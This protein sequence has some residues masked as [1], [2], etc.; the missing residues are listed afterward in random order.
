[1]EEAPLL[2]GRRRRKLK[3]VKKDGS[4]GCNAQKKRWRRKSGEPNEEVERRTRQL[5]LA[6]GKLDEKNKELY[7]YANMDALTKI[8]NRRNYF[9]ESKK[10]LENSEIIL[11]DGQNVI[12]LNEKIIK[13]SGEE[14]FEAILDTASTKPTK[15]IYEGTQLKNILKDNNMNLNK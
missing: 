9:I 4:I 15:H 12:I 6:Y 5:H 13:Q 14:T 11:T 7:E 3:I 1:M 2:V 8:R 10:L